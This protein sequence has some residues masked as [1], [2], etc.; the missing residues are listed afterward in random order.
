MVYRELL[1]E[2]TNNTETDEINDKKLT[3]SFNEFLKVKFYLIS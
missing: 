3:D 2:K 1:Y